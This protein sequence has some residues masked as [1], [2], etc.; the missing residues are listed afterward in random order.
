MKAKAA[1]EEIMSDKK[2]TLSEMAQV[3]DSWRT[4]I[5]ERPN[6]EYR[7]C[8]YCPVRLDILSLSYIYELEKWICA[9]CLARKARID[10]PH[11]AEMAKLG[12]VRL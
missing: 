11:D 8:D 9:N 3:G 4:D 6:A 12:W 1:R 5:P 10:T 2:L 7:R